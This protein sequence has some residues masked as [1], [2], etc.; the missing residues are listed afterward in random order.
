M[1]I[2]T[3]LSSTP[4]QGRKS[5]VLDTNVLLYDPQ[6]LAVF[7]GQ[8]VVIPITVIEEVDKFK[9]DLN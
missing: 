4:G 7:G 1:S 5:F 6:C 2:D 9:K 8:E 3:H